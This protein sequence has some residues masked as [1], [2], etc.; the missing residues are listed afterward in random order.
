MF[1]L[2]IG[3]LMKPTFVLNSGYSFSLYLHKF[4]NNTSMIGM[5]T[6]SLL[7]FVLQLE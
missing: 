3:Q 4:A 5:H 1:A 6:N 7:S 2:V